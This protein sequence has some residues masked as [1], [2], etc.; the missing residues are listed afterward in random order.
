M[1]PALS[2]L[3]SMESIDAILSLNLVL[4]CPP[5]FRLGGSSTRKS[6]NPVSVQG[7]LL[8]TLS[9]LLDV[10]TAAFHPTFVELLN[11]LS[12]VYASPV[13]ALLLS[14]ST[15]LVLSFD[16]CTLPGVDFGF[17]PWL[18]SVFEPALA[19]REPR[20]RCAGLLGGGG[21][22]AQGTALSCSAGAVPLLACVPGL[23]ISLPA[24]DLF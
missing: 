17:S 22:E 9:S 7:V 2:M 10:S 12:S 24:E 18:D 11:L 6:K 19:D 15:S 4:A 1:Q 20:F 16:L 13:L 8:I 21:R 14:S 23:S 3:R 5:P